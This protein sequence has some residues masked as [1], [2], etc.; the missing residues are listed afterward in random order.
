MVEKKID[1]IEAGS[2]CKLGR[3]NREI[4]LALLAGRRP[5]RGG[6]KAIAA[7]ELETYSSLW[8]PGDMQGLTH[9]GSTFQKHPHAAAASRHQALSGDFSNVDIQLM[10]ADKRKR[11]CHVHCCAQRNFV[12]TSTCALMFNLSMGVQRERSCR[13]RW[14]RSWYGGGA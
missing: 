3:N 1:A 10:Y 13:L 14:M 7:R 11:E 9:S 5:F 12:C 4:N 2:H 6:D 8:R